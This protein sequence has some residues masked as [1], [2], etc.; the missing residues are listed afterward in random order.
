MAISK[1][2]KTEI[3]NKLVT[4]MKDAKSIAFSQ[5]HGVSVSDINDIR[6]KMRE[7]GVNYGVAKKT[8]IRLAAKEIGIE[9][10]PDETL[11]GPV[12]LA[13]SMEDEIA[14]AK[15]VNDFSKK[16]K[17]LKLLGAIFEGKLL[18]QAEATELANLP[19]KEE[20]IAKFIYLVK[21]PV[22]GFHGVL[23]NTVSG[24]VRA[25]NAIKEKQEQSV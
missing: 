17:G 10:I 23:N 14:G 18:S 25:L 4:Q 15:L 12:A 7:E 5:F 9:D 21:Y 24:F 6:N 20:L 11:D 2:Q 8:L 22:I 1:E 3:L 16:F 19:S 13:F